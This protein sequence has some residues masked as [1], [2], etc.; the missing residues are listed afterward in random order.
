M[1]MVLM[2]M[3]IMDLVMAMGK[4]ARGITFRKKR[5]AL[6]Q[7]LKINSGF[8]ISETVHNK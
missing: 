5:K 1:D 3:V 4:V 6:Y 7:G 8:N 2:G